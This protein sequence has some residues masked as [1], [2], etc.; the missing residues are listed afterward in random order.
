LDQ[1][2]V[3]LLIAGTYTPFTLGVL[4]GPWG[5]SLFG[6]VWFG[7]FAGVAMRVRSSSKRPKLEN[8]TYLAMGWLVVV[9]IGPLVERIGWAGLGWLVAGGIA[10]SVGVVFLSSRRRFGHCAW[11]LFVLGGSACHTVAV[12][13]YA[14]NS[15]R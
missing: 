15:A 11:H 3:Y 1:S 2:A 10:Y 6:L 4:R 5:W 9:A 12:L 14:I 7:A 13:G 8:L